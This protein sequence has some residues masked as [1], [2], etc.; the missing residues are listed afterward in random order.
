MP[1]PTGQ[2]PTVTA[3]AESGALCP[4]CGGL[5]IPDADTGILS[6]ST[7]IVW[8]NCTECENCTFRA[9][10]EALNEEEGDPV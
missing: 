4:R 6:L 9:A 10:L 7:T 8:C 1:V 5:C 3:L 2:D